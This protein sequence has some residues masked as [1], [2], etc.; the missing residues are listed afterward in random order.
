MHCAVEARPP[1]TGE[2]LHGG[3]QV[4]ARPGATAWSLPAVRVHDDGQHE[5]QTAQEGA[6]TVAKSH[7]AIAAHRKPLASC[8]GPSPT[9]HLPA[10][11]ADC[12][13][14]LRLHPSA[15]AAGG[16]G[17]AAPRLPW[18][19]RCRL[20]GRLRW[21]TRASGAGPAPGEAG[22][23]SFRS[24][25]HRHWLHGPSTWRHKREAGVGSGPG[26]DL[27]GAR[28]QLPGTAPAIGRS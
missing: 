26:P 8:S 13:H 9:A 22:R 11:H 12:P 14:H 25:S 28:Q 27:A 21:A 1:T 24:S 23:W 3:Q 7:A 2:E 6:N 5:R 4:Q 15:A 18:Q 10:A 20:R 16:K 19:G 17:G